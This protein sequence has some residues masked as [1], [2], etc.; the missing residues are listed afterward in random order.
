M[1]IPTGLPK[2]GVFI[3]FLTLC[4]LHTWA[5]DDKKAIKEIEAHRK[6]QQKECRDKVKSPL[7]P[8]D[9]KKF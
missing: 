9:L 6:K 1:R 3:A 2:S 4:F 8:E 5:Q 7:L